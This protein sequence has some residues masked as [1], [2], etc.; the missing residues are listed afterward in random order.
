MRSSF[1]DGWRYMAH[2]FE[3]PGMRRCFDASRRLCFDGDKHAGEGRFALHDIGIGVEAPVKPRARPAE[4]FE[5]FDAG[6]FTLRRRRRF[7]SR[8]GH[9]IIYLQPFRGVK[10]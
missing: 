1:D 4:T 10:R 3:E 2:R 8:H 7:D 6:R 5:S 9:F